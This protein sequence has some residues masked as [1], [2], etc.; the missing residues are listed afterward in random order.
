M[1]V[2][3]EVYSFSREDSSDLFIKVVNSNG[4]PQ[5]GIKVTLT[6]NSV[7][8]VYTTDQNGLTPSSFTLNGDTVTILA[9]DIPNGLID[10]LSFTSNGLTTVRTLTLQSPEYQF[11]TT[12]P[13]TRRFSLS[14]PELLYVFPYVNLS[15]TLQAQLF[16]TDASQSSIIN[17]TSTTSFT[18]GQVKAFDI[19]EDTNNYTQQ[20]QA[21]TIERIE[22]DLPD[23]GS[24]KLI[25]YPY[26]PKSSQVKAIY[27]HNSQGGLDSVICTGDQQNTT[28]FEAI[29]SVKALDL[30]SNFADP[31]VKNTNQFF[32]DNFNINTGFMLQG[33]MN[34][35]KDLK[36]INTA[37]EYNN[38]TFIPIDIIPD[39]LQLPSEKNNLKAASFSYKHAFEQRAIDRQ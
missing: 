35:L 29:Q 11:L 5:Q 9:E 33:E 26:T 18:Q 15:T 7:S 3:G 12:K 19:S 14:H 2:L 34:A 6:I 38:G 4:V 8:T 23:E 37:Y 39:S 17:L 28:D 24:D 22:I 25:L 16:Y 32:T 36:L 10:T 21:K 1:A 27:Y 30:A 13:L 31:Q 20:N